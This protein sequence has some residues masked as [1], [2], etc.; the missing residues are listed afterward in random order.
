MTPA[1]YR[2][3]WKLPEEYPMIPPALL[4]RRGVTVEVDPETGDFLE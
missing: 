4:R 3:K 1:A 2:R